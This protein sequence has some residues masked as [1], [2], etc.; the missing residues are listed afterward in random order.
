MKDIPVFYDFSAYRTKGKDAPV[1]CFAEGDVET[2]NNFVYQDKKAV[3][4]NASGSGIIM[5]P[6]HGW[7]AF[8]LEQYYRNG[9]VEFDICGTAGG[10]DFSIGLRSDTKGVTLTHSVSLRELNIN[11]PD[12]WQHIKIPVKSIAG[13]NDDGFSIQNITMLVISN[14]K[15]QKFYLSEMYITSP[16][17]EKL[18]PVIKVNQIG[19]RLNHAKFALVSCF[20]GTVNLSENI[21]FKVIGKN[22]DTQFTGKLQAVK[23]NVDESSGE[24]VFKADFTKLNEAGEYRISIAGIDV[25]DSFV[26]SIGGNVYDDLFVDALKYFYIQRQGIDIETRHAG[27]FAR[28]NLHPGDAAVKKLSERDK[29]GAETRDLTQGWYDAGD[30][31]KYFP[32]AAATVSDL[33]FAY[34]MFPALFIDNQFN[35]PESGNGLPDLLDEIKWELDMMLKME[36]G[37]TGGFWEVA[38]YDYDINTIFIIDT[39]GENGAA[40][41]ISTAATA[42][43]AAVFSHAYIVYKNIPRHA[44]FAEKCLDAAKRAW[45]YLEAHPGNTWVYGIKRSYRRSAAEV[46]M[47]KFRAAAALYRAAGTAKFS[48]YVLKTYQGFDY[49][50]EFNAVE[51]YTMGSLGTGFMHY[52]LAPSPDKELI[53]FFEAKFAGFLAGYLKHYNENTWPALIPE[54]AYFW[55]SNAAICRTSVELYMGSR[56]LGKDLRQPVQLIRDSVHYLLGIN[57]LSFSFV[58]GY[59]ENC[60]RNIYSLIYTNDKIDEIPRGFMAGG[61]NQYESGFMSEWPSKCYVDSDREW[62]TNEHAIY[63][64]AVF[65]FCLTVERG[66]AGMETGSK[67]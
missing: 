66:T 17:H 10:E 62:T 39:N 67:F 32:P 41:T 33:L 23:N 35:I 64:N 55:G 52:A 42:S 28:K 25:D 47:M 15:A 8:S 21:E 34:E 22:K 54:W 63:W 1:F 53:K 40:N 16:D 38:N 57:P 14:P 26:F 56:I 59:G 3:V 31:G 46:E 18:H 37:T 61:A 36:D 50:R 65:A 30:Y 48:D 6:L 27:V 44:A 45:A 7:G 49:K 19:Y 29:L 5:F 12:S 43:A 51:V 2:E 9:F 20:P 60:V 4:V 58:S 24:L 13:K 11:V